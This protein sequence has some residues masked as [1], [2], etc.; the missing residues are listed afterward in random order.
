MSEDK[1]KK[2]PDEE[3]QF[4]SED[5]QTQSDPVN[6]DQGSQL[7]SFGS[8]DDDL[9]NLP[10]LSDFE[11][12]TSSGGA[13]DD[14]FG[15]L[16][17]LSDINVETPQAKRSGDK[18]TAITPG[19]SFATPMSDSDLETP[20]PG[21]LETPHGG[22]QTA[23]QDLTADSDFSPETPE[24]GPGPDSDLETPMFDSAFGGGDF[25]TPSGRSTDTPTQAMETPMFAGG[26][27][28]AANNNNDFGFDE[29]AFGGGDF[30]GGGAAPRG[31]R[32]FDAGTPV[33]D[34]SPDTGFP[35][36][37][38][39]AAM[40]GGGKGK[41]A[42]GGGGAGGILV[43]A[44]ALIVGLVGGV[45]GGPMLGLG[46]ANQDVIDDLESQ[47]AAKD[48]QIQN[49]QQINSQMTPDQ[50]G[51]S[52]EQL[53][54]ERT[55]LTE[56]V[57]A[58]NTKFTELDGQVATLDTQVAD[59]QAELDALSAEFTAASDTFA[60]L[61]NQNDIIRAQQGGL[62]AEVERYK[63]LV[64]ELDDANT[65]RALTR[66]AL[67]HSVDRLAVTVREGNPLTP[68]RYNLDD[69][70][71]RVDDL[72]SKLAASNWVDPALLNEYTA[73]YLDELEIAAGR[74]YFFARIPVADKYGNVES[75]WAECVMNGNWSVYFRTIDGKQVGVFEDVAQSGAP[76]Y[77][78][79]QFLEPASEKQIA[80]EVMAARPAD[81]QEKLTVI[82]E[83]QLAADD[84]TPM[85]R[86]YD[87][88]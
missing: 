17:P 80:Q 44:I 2:N 75:K 34:F 31:G 78:F 46:G 19:A 21:N 48:T 53:T 41:K 22:R 24:I 4:P 7:G 18:P 27:G 87:S 81:W 10:P 8:P 13:A 88:L 77:D 51:M 3:F 82:A 76:R 39:G 56:E 59:R 57:A 36:A 71:A 62:L 14:D 28:R 45:F 64:G 5:F 73:L 58:L 1:D 26:G 12:T 74:E 69:R 68:E 83:R 60:D 67:L 79:R 54:A 23:F 63:Q 37:G 86:W 66:D 32:G 85:Q 42:K 11:S 40:A 25:N 61:T 35:A 72:R 15:G 49:L 55:R 47:I 70:I 50:Q 6:K 65:R 33:P 9:G 84:R 30:G 29:G 43:A 16:P 20:M 52:I 38:G